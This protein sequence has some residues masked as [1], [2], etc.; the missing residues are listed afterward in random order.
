MSVPGP[1]PPV[2]VAVS[3]RREASI[4]RR[5]ERRQD[6]DASEQASQG[7]V[8]QIRERGQ[9]APERIRVGEQLWAG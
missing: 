3:D 9:I 5:R 1:E 8:E 4:A 6:V 7:P 2:D